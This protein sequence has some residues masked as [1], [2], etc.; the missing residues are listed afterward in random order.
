MT[1][2]AWEVSLP[3]CSYNNVQNNWEDEDKKKSLKH[4]SKGK[5][6]W[7]KKSCISSNYLL[8]D[9]VAETMTFPPVSQ[10]TLQTEKTMAFS[11]PPKISAQDT[12]DNKLLQFSIFRKNRML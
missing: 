6:Q 11:H 5:Y 7:K 2:W 3:P 12:D 1:T 4:F 9:V 10:R 8:D